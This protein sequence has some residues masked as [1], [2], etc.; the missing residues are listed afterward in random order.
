MSAREL[1]N[2]LKSLDPFTLSAEP[3]EVSKDLKVTD[4]RAVRLP[5]PPRGEPRYSTDPAS[6]RAPAVREWLEH[7]LAGRIGGN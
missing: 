6:A 1:E 3:V 2:F 5:E 4:P 7:V